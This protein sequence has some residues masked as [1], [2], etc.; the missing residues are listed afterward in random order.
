MS[1]NDK[2]NLRFEKNSVM[3][4]HHCS[5]GGDWFHSAQILTLENGIYGHRDLWICDNC[6]RL[7]EREI[8]LPK[9]V[10]EELLVEINLNE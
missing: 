8:K 9:M 7:Y 6:G 4:L 1:N 5:C 2:A 10:I 3:N